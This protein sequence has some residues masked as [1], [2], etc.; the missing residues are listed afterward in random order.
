[1]ERPL[2]IW[3][4]GV[5]AWSRWGCFC[6]MARAWR[7]GTRSEYM[8]ARS[9]ARSCTPARPLVHIAGGKHAPSLG[10]RACVGGG[11]RW[12]GRVHARGESC[13]YWRGQ[14]AAQSEGCTTHPP[15][16]NPRGPR[17][18]G[19]EGKRHCTAPALQ[20]SSGTL[21][22]RRAPNG[23]GRG[24]PRGVE[25][26]LWLGGRCGLRRMRVAPPAEQGPG[27]RIWTPPCRWGLRTRACWRNP[28]ISV[29]GKARNRAM[30]PSLSRGVTMPRRSH[31]ETTT[32]C[33]L[34]RRGKL[35]GTFLPFLR[36]CPAE[37]RLPE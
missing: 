35:E 9:P 15:A 27:T 26:A 11:A 18:G 21:G 34:S 28:R 29:A 22:G 20:C 5:G 13:A 8:P 30:E 31:P 10:E 4:A 16:P 33:M 7:I 36:I 23:G 17:R 1:M 32:T 14:N 25:C 3:R 12:G 24:E 19:R 6:A 2:C 37:Y